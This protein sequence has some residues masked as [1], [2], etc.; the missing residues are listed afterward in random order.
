MG[1]IGMRER[2]ALVGGT[3]EVE[4][5]PG[6]GATVFVRVPVELEP[7]DGPASQKGSDE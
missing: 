1:L 2:A 6:G 5:T 4:S 7:A 3:V